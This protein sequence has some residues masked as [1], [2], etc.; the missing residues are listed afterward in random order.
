MDGIDT[1]MTAIEERCGELDRDDEDL[2]PK[3]K[4]LIDTCD[5]LREDV[6]SLYRNLDNVE[7]IVKEQAV[8]V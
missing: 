4:S 8:I 1:R 5:S 6:T 7:Q 3:V 2:V